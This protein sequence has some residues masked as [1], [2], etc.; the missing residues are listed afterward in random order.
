MIF[1]SLAMTLIAAN[2]ST[3]APHNETSIPP[4]DLAVQEAAQDADKTI[5]D[6]RRDNE[7]PTLYNWNQ[8]AVRR[9]L[10]EQVDTGG[11]GIS[12]GDDSNGDDGCG[13]QEPNVRW[14]R[15]LRDPE[16]NR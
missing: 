1:Y 7:R 8:Q 6:A 11:G 14:S 9:E 15:Q 3:T 16:D 5:A 12:G 10:S 2:L 4:E 13:C